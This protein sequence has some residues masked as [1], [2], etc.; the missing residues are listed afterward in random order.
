MLR[1]EIAN[2]FAK[3]FSVD[4]LV[5]GS[6][7]LLLPVYLHL[8]TQEEVGTFNYIFV[9]IQTISV[10]L[11]FGLYQAQSKLYHDYKGIE[12]EQLLFSINLVLFAFLAVILLPIYVFGFDF[13]LMDFVFGNSINYEL[14]RWP[15]LLAFITSVGSYLLFN[16]LLTSEN[17]RKVQIYNLLKMI[18]SNGIV[19][20]ILYVS[21]SDKV[22]TR[23]IVYYL[24]EIM[25]WICFL[26]SYVKQFRFTFDWEKIKRILSICIPTFLLSLISTILGFS[27]KYFVRQKT[28]MSI[29]AV[30][31]VGITISSVCYL[32]IMSFQNVWMP[33]FLKEKNVEENFRKTG[34]LVKI[35]IGSFIG[36]AVIMII[37]V[38]IAL[39]FNIIPTSYGEVLKILPFLFIAQ[40]ISSVNTLYGNYFLYFNRMTLGSLV[41]GSVYIVSFFINFWLIP[42][43]GVTGAVIAI[44]LNNIVLLTIV[45]SVVKHL[46]RNNINS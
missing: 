35:I 13:Q 12:R 21:K 27:D 31:T 22:I 15:L 24:C 19:I 38:K 25:L 43:Y 1:N 9:F 40:I 7:F 32:V 28:D 33:I 6:T 8:M 45:Y 46:Y 18:I 30:Y 5:K 42:R 3:V 37:G 23:L 17:I 2:R 29:M 44:L 36:I 4:V 14:F 11:I 10:L 41:G 34:K 39:M 16:Y 26:F 20:V